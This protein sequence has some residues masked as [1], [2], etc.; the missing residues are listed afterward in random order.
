M[1]RVSL[2]SSPFFL[3]FEHFEQLLDQASRVTDG[4]P[5]YNIERF[6]ASATARESWR[7]S[8]AVAGFAG[9]DLEVTLEDRQ[10]GIR[11]AHR[12][13]QGD[14]DRRDYMHR[15][16]AGRSFVKSFVLADGMEV[17]N[18]RL[19]NGLLLISLFRRAAERKILRIEVKE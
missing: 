6:P 17:E 10:L 13:A 1:A 3:G 8:L 4:F 16:I 2:F 15:G 5:P 9:A 19:E 12:G 11:G 14:E 18:A 7:I